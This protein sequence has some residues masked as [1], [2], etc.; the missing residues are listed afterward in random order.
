[1]RAFIE[2]TN[3]VIELLIA[4][5]FFKQ[6]LSVRPLSNLS[7]FTTI[8]GVLCVHILR[9]FIP[10]PVY[11]NFTVSGVLLGTYVIVLFKDMWLKKL[12][13]FLL[14]F[15]VITTTDILCRTILSIMTNTASSFASYTDM[16]RYIGMTLF[17]IVS[18]SLLSFISAFAKK[19]LQ[20]VDFKYWI[21]ML[22]FPLFSLFIVIC[23]D[24]FIVLSG[25]SNIYYILLLTIIIIGLLYFNTTV[26]EFIE[27]YS[28]KI[29]LKNAKELIKYQQQNYELLEINEKELRKLRHDIHSHIEVMRSMLDNHL[30][31]ESSQLAESLQIL[32]AFP[33]SITY[34][35]DSSLDSILNIESKKATEQHIKFSVTTHNMFSPIR[36][37]PIDKINIL[38]NALNNAIESCSNVEDKFILVDIASDEKTIKIR[39]ENSSLPL[40]TSGNVLLTTKKDSINHGFGIESIRSSLKKYDGILSITHTN[41]IT[42]YSIVADNSKILN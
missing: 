8:F 2:I 1:M 10:I 41:G 9:S 29:Q 31:S 28:A 5:F 25:A 30:I 14:Y 13:V 38:C 6:M 24:I 19:R 3:C 15:T 12:G 21:I 17:S 26:F 18:L 27:S 34:T 42:K 37:D 4:L 39:V 32:S 40:K 33:T 23:C 16:Q 20:N 11:L 36:I 22:L 7:K 35:N